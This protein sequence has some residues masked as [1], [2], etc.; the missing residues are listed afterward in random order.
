MVET[1]Q[2]NGLW[3]LSLAYRDLIE[4]G[5]LNEK[6][7]ESELICLKYKSRRM[8]ISHTFNQ[9][10]V[11]SIEGKADKDLENLMDA[12]SKVVEYN[13]FCKYNLHYNSMESSTKSLITYEWDK[14]DLDS[15]FKELS[16]KNNITNLSRTIQ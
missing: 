1:I 3:H 5:G 16:E 2:S 6:D 12:F 7:L 15:R 10:L 4:Q 11:V 13:P 8:V 9:H 14:V